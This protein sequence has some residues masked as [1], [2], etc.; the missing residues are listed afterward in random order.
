M[1][2]F[3]SA[4]FRFGEIFKAGGDSRM[5]GERFARRPLVAPTGDSSC[6]RLSDKKGFVV[7][8]GTEDGK[9]PGVGIQGPTLGSSV[10]SGDAP[11]VLVSDSYEILRWSDSGVRLQPD[12]GLRLE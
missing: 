11:C 7:D 6:F 10:V 1:P 2:L 5:P 8:H 9:G 12:S 3:A 4:Y